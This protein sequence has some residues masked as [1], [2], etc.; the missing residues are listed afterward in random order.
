MNLYINLD[1]LTLVTSAA[2]TRPVTRIE[3]KRGDHAP[4]AI[5]FIRA[6]ALVRL[7]ATTVLSFACKENAAYDADLLVS[8]NTFEQSEI[9]VD[10]EDDTDPHWTG[11]PSFNTEELNAL[12]L[13]NDDPDDDPAYLDLMAEFTWL[14]DGDDGPTSTAT[15][16]VR[17]HNDVIRGNETF[18]SAIAT[19]GPGTPV[20]AVV[21]TGT[22]EMTGANNDWDLAAVNAGA[23]ANDYTLTVAVQA[24]KATDP[25]VAIVVGA[26]TITAGDNAI[27]SVDGTFT[28]NGSNFIAFND[29]DFTYDSLFA[30]KPYFTNLEG[31][32]IQWDGTQWILTHAATG[33]SYRSAEN[34]ATPDLVV[35]WTPEGAATGTPVMTPRVHTAAQCKTAFDATAANETLFTIANKAGNDGHGSVA[36]FG[37]VTLS[38]GVDG[39][40]APAGGVLF[41][42]D[43]LYIAIDATT[44]SDSSGWRKVALASL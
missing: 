23:A 24:D 10:P 6:G 32:N 31:D 33:A 7:D 29:S 3:L 13:I 42:S 25:T 41:D 37:P 34:V 36:A 11:A 44:V 9:P 2:D 15:F 27:L 19:S 18:P 16:A 39:T 5:R 43:F 38:G 28:S 8:D 26:V 30:G 4:F 22:T 20:E 1:T 40:A 14:A 21:A 17:V 35:T 12:F